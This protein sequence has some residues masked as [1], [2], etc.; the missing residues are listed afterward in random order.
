[1]FQISKEE[2]EYVRARTK[3]VHIRVLNKFH[4]AR[5]KHYYIDESPLAK[6]LLEEFW[7]GKNIDVMEADG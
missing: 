7:A 2:A 6:R 4:V 3:N 5:H 1:M